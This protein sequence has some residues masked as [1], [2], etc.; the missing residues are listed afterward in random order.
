MRLVD[1]GAE[2][3]ADDLVTIEAADIL[4]SSVFKKSTPQ[5]PSS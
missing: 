1:I 4:G 5:S 3:S 2:I